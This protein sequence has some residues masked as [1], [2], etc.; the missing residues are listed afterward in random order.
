M[1]ENVCQHTLLLEHKV[2]LSWT[3]TATYIAHA[4]LPTRA[5]RSAVVAG[6]ILLEPADDDGHGCVGAHVHQLWQD[7]SVWV[8]FRE[9]KKVALTH[10]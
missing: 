10:E 1:T 5:N 2:L 7:E 9:R 4:D 6:E 8:V 3:L